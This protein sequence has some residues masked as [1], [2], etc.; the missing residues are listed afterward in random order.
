MKHILIVDDN[1]TSLAT[2]RS[3][4]S[5]LY[6]ITAVTMGSQAIKFLEKNTCDLILLDINMPEIDGFE[7]MKHIRENPE[8]NNI[9]I[10]FLTADSDPV[11]ESRCF[12]EGALDFI[13]KPFVA[14]VMHSRI[15]RILELE[16]SR[17]MLANKL[18]EKIQEVAEIKS[19]SQQDALTH[20]W[21]RSYTENAVN[22]LINE[23]AG[24]VLFM[25]D[26]DNFKAIN[27]NY[28][29]IEG[30]NTLMMFADTMRKYASEGDILC[31]IGG[32]EFVMFVKAP[33]SMADIR[34]LAGDIISDICHKLDEK[35]LIQI[36]RYLSVLHKFPRTAIIL[37]QPITQPI[38]LFIM[39][40]KTEKIPTT[41]SANKKRRKMSV[42]QI[43]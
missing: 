7:V 33:T 36:H 43:L 29:H 14:A 18:E 6:K 34:N 24:G 40:S 11:T 2:A 10:I 8:R 22:A 3:E 26:M 39:L 32:D 23:G 16:D 35:S 28:G 13:S 25:I 21:N 9:P 5:G 4:L 12:E 31:R 17:R 42:P 37:T 20:L 41:F 38:R 15:A 30:D 1:K 27:D 19:K